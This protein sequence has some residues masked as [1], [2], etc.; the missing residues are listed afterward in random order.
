MK[1]RTSRTETRNFTLIELLV[2]VAIIAILAGMLL[3]ALNAA[4]ERARN[5][6]CTGNLKQMGTAMLSYT[7]DHKDWFPQVYVNGAFFISISTNGACWDGQ[8]GQ[9]VGYVYRGVAST[10]FTSAQKVFQCPS[11]E[12]Y[13]NSDRMSR[14]YS[15]NDT[16]AGNSQPN[17]TKY[18]P[19]EYN[20]RTFGHTK[21]P[22]QMV[23]ID[24]GDPDNNFG[25]L[26]YGYKQS[27]GKQYVARSTFAE[28]TITYKRHGRTFNFVRKDG[29]V[30]RSKRSGNNFNE[31]FLYFISKHKNTVKITATSVSEAEL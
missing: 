7:V 15:M 9:Y 30:H 23:L 10:Y 16:V 29:S 25:N 13:P 22:E 11:A 20:A 17:L 6:Q 26:M 24:Y 2:V 28:K 18:F 21:T 19:A 3:P 1:E 4:R 5:I 31:D 12:K 14:G 8:I 27:G